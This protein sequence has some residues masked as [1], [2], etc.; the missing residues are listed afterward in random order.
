MFY[1]DDDDLVVDS[2]REEKGR[3]ETKDGWVDEYG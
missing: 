2:E 1:D 3:K